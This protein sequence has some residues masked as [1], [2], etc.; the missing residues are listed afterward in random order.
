MIE[1]YHCDSQ[2]LYFYN[3]LLFKA[4]N[5]YPICVRSWSLCWTGK[6]D[7]ILRLKCQ[8][9]SEKQNFLMLKLVGG[10]F[11]D[12]PTAEVAKQFRIVRLASPESNYT[13]N[14]GRQI[15]MK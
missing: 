9:I 15:L 6:D 14:Q 3:I 2:F 12:Q 10:T 8:N 4:Y 1:S 11:P 5:V 13:S 7:S